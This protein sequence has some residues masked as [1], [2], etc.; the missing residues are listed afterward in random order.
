M[1]DMDDEIEDLKQTVEN[2]LQKLEHRHNPFPGE[3]V[4]GRGIEVRDAAPFPA[5]ERGPIA[6][7]GD[8]EYLL[9]GVIAEMHY[10]M[11]ELALPTAADT[12]DAD[13][14]R[15]FITSS[16]EIAHAAAKVGKTV[17]GLRAASQPHASR[18]TT[19]KIEVV[20]AAPKNC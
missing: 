8:T 18:T 3:L 20:G 10:L 15:R 13:V 7:E 12:G 4:A 17:A 14:R 2:T 6:C 5:P 11:R 1:A 16:I 9:N 19:E